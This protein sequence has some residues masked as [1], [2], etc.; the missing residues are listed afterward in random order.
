MSNKDMNKYRVTPP[1]YFTIRWG[2]PEYTDWMDESMSWKENCYIGDWSFLWERWFRG[3]DVEKLFSDFSTL[4]FKKFEIGQAKHCIHCNVDGK[5]IHEG[6]LTRFGQQEYLLFGR[7]CF[8]MNYNLEKGNYNVTSE[9]EDWFNLQVSGPNAVAL[10]EKSCGESLR[11]VKYMYIKKIKIRGKS[12]YALRQGMAGEPGFELVGPH[13]WKEEIM[14]AVLED[15]AEFGIRRLGGRTVFI[16]H[17]E[18][19]FPTIITDYIPA[20][21]SS[22]L[23]DYLNAFKSSMPASMTTLNLYGSFEGNDISD[24][25]RSPIELGWSKVVKFDHDFLGREA[26]EKEMAN[27]RRIMRTLVWNPEDVVDVYASL[28]KKGDHY[29]F[30]EF[31]RYQRGGMYVD[32]VMKDG[33]LVGATS[34]YGYSYYFR[35]MLCLAVIDI[36]QAQTGNEVKII[37]G[38]PGH[39]QKEIRA[40]VAEAPYKKDR[41][42]GDL[43]LV[44]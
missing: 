32:K 14:Q 9:P 20:M 17:L 30:I 12:I 3:P 16:N 31:P 37:W 1:G 25:Y 38:A 26:L 44:R 33:K 43:H 10:L 18:A 34:S 27:P 5:V 40:T 35:E 2:E 6:I 28:F 39:P 36:D 11:D 23:T 22:D 19:C 8:W 7:G 4:S 42:K 15:G 24:Y 21:F 29:D 41:S 13:E